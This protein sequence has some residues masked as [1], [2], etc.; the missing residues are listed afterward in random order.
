LLLFGLLF[1]DAE[2]VAG[3][4]MY[5]LILSSPYLFHK[6]AREIKLSS[7]EQSSVKSSLVIERDSVLSGTQRPLQ[8]IQGDSGPTMMGGNK[9]RVGPI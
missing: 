1:V 8:R 5:L 2:K 4:I 6:N 7:N 9:K 3:A